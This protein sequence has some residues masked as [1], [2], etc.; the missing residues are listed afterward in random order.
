MMDK[1]LQEEEPDPVERELVNFII[2]TPNVVKKSDMNKLLNIISRYAKRLYHKKDR[3]SVRD[4][5]RK[6][7]V[8][9]KN[10]SELII[11]KNYIFLPPQEKEHIIHTIA[12]QLRDIAG[13]EKR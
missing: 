4:N 5:I 12:R 7:I 6:F 10:R 1:K 13:A 3:R 8:N 9:P 2:S 11:P